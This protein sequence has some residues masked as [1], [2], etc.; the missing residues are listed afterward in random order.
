M[1]GVIV[2]YLFIRSGRGRLTLDLE[3]DFR[4]QYSRLAGS[5]V[6]VTI[7]KY[8]DPRT[9]RANAYL[10]ALITQIG[11][12][13]RL[14]KDEVY[15]EMLKSYGQGGSLSVE[16]NYAPQFERSYKYHE[17]LGESELNGKTFRHFR[18]WVGSH[19]Y[20]RDEFRVLL[21]GVI[22]EARNLGIEVRTPEEINSLLSEFEDGRG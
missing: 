22:Q 8:S 20:N 13:M 18:F 11:N 6:E 21:D 9:L 7:K 5:E 17:V 2:D 19:E 12:R 3:E 16:L 4:Q 14:G 10:W 15:L 1:K